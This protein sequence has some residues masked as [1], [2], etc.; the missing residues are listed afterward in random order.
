[1]TWVTRYLRELLNLGQKEI[2]NE[3]EPEFCQVHKA[4]ILVFD[5]K[6][7]FISEHYYSSNMLWK[8]L[9]CTSY[10]YSPVK[11]KVYKCWFKPDTTQVPIKDLPKEL[12]AINLLI[13]RG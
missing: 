3:P 1:M 6:G 11:S 5:F 4:H 7:K 9:P 8:T 13:N 10:I 12:Q 2:I